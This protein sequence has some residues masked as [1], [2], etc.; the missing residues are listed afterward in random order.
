MS[1]KRQ[2]GKEILTEKRRPP[3]A[4]VLCLVGM[5]GAVFAF[6][7]YMLNTPYFPYVLVGYM[8]ALSALVIGYILYNKGFVWARYEDPMPSDEAENY[9]FITEG[10]RRKKRSEWMLIFIFPIIFTFGIDVLLLTLGENILSL[11]KD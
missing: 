7:R 3:I 5:T 8:A 2:K 6:Y 9:D 11:F 10:K 4:K 1:K